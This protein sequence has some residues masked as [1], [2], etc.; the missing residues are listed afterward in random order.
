MKDFYDQ[1]DPRGISSSEYEDYK[2]ALD[3]YNK[4]M[5]TVKKINGESKKVS[6]IC[7]LKNHIL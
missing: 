3:R 6:S 7:D 1:S 5:S 4:K 2:N